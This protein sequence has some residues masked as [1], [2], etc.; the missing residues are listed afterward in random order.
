MR[1]LSVS[2]AV[3]LSLSSCGVV[4]SIGAASS[5]N[6][7]SNDP[8]PPNR[9]VTWKTPDSP[10]AS[11][12]GSLMSAARPA[13]ASQARRRLE[14]ETIDLSSY[15]IKFEKCLY[16]KQYDEDHND[17]TVLATQK[18]VVFRLCYDS[19]GMCS[20]SGCKTNY[21]EY[22]IDMDT[23]LEATLQHKK[24][25]QDD[26]CEA[27]QS[28]ATDAAAD[29]GGRDRRRSRR[30]RATTTVD[31]DTC[32]SQCQN[33][34]SMEE[35][36]YVDA[37]EYYKCEKVYKN[38]NTGVV[39]YAGAMCDKSGTRIKVGLFTDEYCETYDADAAPDTYIKKNGYNVKLSYH[40]MKHTFT[41][42]DCV[43]SCMGV[44]DDDDDGDG[45]YAEAVTADVCKTLYE[46]AG[47]CETPHSF[48]S[49]IASYSDIYASQVS[50]EGTVCEYIASI[51]S[52]A[53]DESGELVVKSSKTINI[54]GGT[55]YDSVQ[56]TGGQKFALTFFII[57]TV[58]F[59][60]YAVFLRQRVNQAV[61]RGIIA[62]V[63][64]GGTMA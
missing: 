58:G 20:S 59:V 42:E 64:G 41:T 40:L 8:F 24:N 55:K 6:N 63:G 27:C 44:D 62:H 10:Y 53:Y 18:L 1:L 17:E 23:Y 32:Y 13:P 29:G 5:S 56:T 52:G 57:G 2:A 38:D 15:S 14:E 46:A 36:G 35:Y 25:E 45:D 7:N 43:A 47:K 30:R 22:V 16:I 26:Y 31:C 50:N 54:V 60:A 21:G 9:V 11:Y 37:A 28:C 12:L 34:D 19:G 4:H 61:R 3:A 48:A 51:N 49:G 39:Y 33:I